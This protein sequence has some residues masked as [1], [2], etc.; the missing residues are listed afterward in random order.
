VEVEERSLGA[1]I[2]SKGSTIRA[3][4]E[5]TGCRLTVLREGRGAGRVA[6]HIA[7]AD[8]AAVGAAAEWVR[9]LVRPLAAGEAWRAEV[10]EVLSNGAGVR[11]SGPPPRQAPHRARPRPPARGGAG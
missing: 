8:A 2:G 5:E 1:V 9:E 6:V 3:I 10:L 11:V 7:G 4:A